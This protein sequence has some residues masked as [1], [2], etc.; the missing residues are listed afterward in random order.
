MVENLNKLKTVESTNKTIVMKSTLNLLEAISI[1]AGYHTV[2][3][4][5]NRVPKSGSVGDLI[6]GKPSLHLKNA[7]AG[8]IQAL[9]EANFTLSLVNGL[10][11]VNDY[12]KH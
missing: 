4:I 12:N 11:A 2:E 8:C 1:I 7:N 6:S 10:I 5:I 3:L 9:D